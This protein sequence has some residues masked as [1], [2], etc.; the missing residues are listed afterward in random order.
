[1]NETITTFPFGDAKH[2]LNKYIK[3]NCKDLTEAKINQLLYLG[4]L[5]TIN[6]IKRW[7]RKDEVVL[8]RLNTGHTRLT[9]SFLL[10]KE[11]APIC[12][13]CDT[14]LTVTH[15]LLE[16]K[17]YREIR[18]QY[19]SSGTLQELKNIKPSYIIRF[20]KDIQLYNEI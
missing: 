13:A 16:C 20:M 5:E 17:K 2:L 9:H 1:M 4:N 18:K 10:K 19:Y 7:N 14:R 12:T 6:D 3:Q 8:C 15:I 11:M